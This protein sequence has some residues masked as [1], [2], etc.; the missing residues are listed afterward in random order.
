MAEVAGRSEVE[1]ICFYIRY[2]Y[3]GKRRTKPL[4]MSLEA[5]AALN[6]EEFKYSIVKSVPYLEACQSSW[7]LSLQDEDDMVDLDTKKFLSLIKNVASKSDKVI[8]NIEES[9][10]PSSPKRF[11]KDQEDGPK[12]DTPL[13][14]VKMEKR[15]YVTDFSNRSDSGSRRNLFTRSSSCGT[16]MPSVAAFSSPLQVLL[17]NLAEQKDVAEEHLKQAQFEHESLEQEFSPKADIDYTKPSCSICHFRAGTKQR[18]HNR[19]NCPTKV[20]CQSARI[21][22]DIEKHPAEK[23]RLRTLKRAVETCEREYKKASA[24]LR[25]NIHI[26]EKSL[27]SKI[28]Q[29]LLFQFPSRYGNQVDCSY[30]RLNLDVDLIMKHCKRHRVT[31]VGAL[32]DLQGLIQR[33]ERE[34]SSDH[35]TSGLAIKK[36]ECFTVHKISPG[37]FAQDVKVVQILKQSRGYGKKRTLSLQIQR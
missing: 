12:C 35:S 37:G 23:D 33:L 1:E 6:Y 5:L 14:G 36:N 27:D 19:A 10:T 18:S 9:F 25:S 13:A 30:Q 22:G 28:R 29:K 32:G 21:C 20:T 16:N 34:T 3:K 24:E 31:S 11:S 2:D 7:R 26:Q 8:I 17:K 4:Y 15:S